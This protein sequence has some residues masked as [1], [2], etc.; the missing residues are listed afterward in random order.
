VTLATFLALN[1]YDLEAPEEEV[2][3]VM[4]GVADRRLGEDRLADWIRGHLVRVGS[5]RRR[6][7]TG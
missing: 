7:R 3:Q 5:V 4:L 1:G 2:V 6:G